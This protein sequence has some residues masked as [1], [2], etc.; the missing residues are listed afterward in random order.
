MVDRR[1]NPLHNKHRQTCLWTIER[2]IIAILQPVEKLW[3]GP[4]W[5]TRISI[6]GDHHA[7]FSDA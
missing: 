2:T 5:V 7:S 4:M 3:G 6:Y 1:I